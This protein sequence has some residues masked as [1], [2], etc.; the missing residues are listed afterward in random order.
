MKGDKSKCKSCGIS[1]TE[2]HSNRVSKYCSRKCMGVGFSGVKKPHNKEWESKRVLAVQEA[3]KHRVYPKGYKRSKEHI[4][5]MLDA[6]EKKRNEDPEKYRQKAIK[7]LSKS[8]SLDLS[9]E[10]NPQWRGG[11]TKEST[12]LRNQYSNKLDKFRSIVLKRDNYSCKNCNE[13][14]NLEVHHI[15]SFKELPEACWMPM[16]G[17]TLCKVCHKKTDTFG[18]KGINAKAISNGAGRTMCFA[19]TIP[20]N[21]QA[22]PTVGNYDWTESGVLI[23]F[24][25]DMGNDRYEKL[26]FLHEFIEA[27]LCEWKGLPEQEITDFDIGFENKRIE[28]NLDEPGFDPAAPYKLEHYFATSVE[29]GMCALAGIDWKE[30]EQK[31]N[32]L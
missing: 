10:N 5:P 15:I 26:V 30:Y 27:T 7:N 28:G 22:Y 4:Q 29:L 1:F 12:R 16:N 3:A 23:I 19:K 25:S 11:L 31:I 14:N 24:I 17:V 9:K 32:N 13:K 8:N 21:F 20:H 2:K 18:A 6:L